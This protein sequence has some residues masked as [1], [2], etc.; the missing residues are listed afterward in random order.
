MKLNARGFRRLF[1][2][3]IS[4]PSPTCVGSS[5][6]VSQVNSLL[7]PCSSL[8]LSSSSYF[9]CPLHSYRNQLYYFSEIFTIVQ[10]LEYLAF[11]KTTDYAQV[12]LFKRDMGVLISVIRV[13]NALHPASFNA[14]IDRMVC[15]AS[16]FSRMFRSFDCMCANV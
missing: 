4:T 1:H 15:R 7:G 2:N 12:V 8:S 9:I 14:P 6:L 5:C 10:S 11:S 3:S 16:I 13:Y